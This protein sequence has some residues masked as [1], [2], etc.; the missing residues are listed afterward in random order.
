MEKLKKKLELRLSQ[1]LAWLGSSLC[2]IPD[3]LIYSILSSRSNLSGNS[4]ES[5]EE[6]AFENLV[7]LK[8]M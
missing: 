8:K 4:L 1:S 5:I 7:L 6:D 2:N 3:L